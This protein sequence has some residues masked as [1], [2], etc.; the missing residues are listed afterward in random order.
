M[1]GGRGESMLLFQQRSKLGVSARE[2]GSAY[3]KRDEGEPNP[4][5]EAS[6]DIS[7]SQM[8]LRSFS[9]NDVVC[10][11]VIANSLLQRVLKATGSAVRS[12]PSFRATYIAVSPSFLLVPLSSRERC[13]SPCWSEARAASRSTA[14]SSSRDA[15]SPSAAQSKVAIRRWGAL[16]S[17]PSRCV[18]LLSKGLLLLWRT[19]SRLLIWRV[20]KARRR[21]S[22]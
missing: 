14:S 9:S 16:A 7:A 21:R 1:L 12:A 22:R 10:R 13:P 20:L 2:T 15:R 4:L 19:G 6:L 5:C 18:L 11:I 8:V 17:W 3:R